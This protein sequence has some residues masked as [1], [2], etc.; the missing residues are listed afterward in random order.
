MGRGLI[1]R[2]GG[3]E[4]EATLVAQL[5]VHGARPVPP[6]A[7]RE[8]PLEPVEAEVPAAPGVGPVQKGTVLTSVGH[9]SSSSASSGIGTSGAASAVLS[10]RGSGGRERWR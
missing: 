9:E 4:L 6:E 5:G 8:C 1:L 2:G 7:E 10:D 3:G